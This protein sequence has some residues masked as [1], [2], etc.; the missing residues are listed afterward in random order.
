[1]AQPS[2]PTR[3]LTPP[4]HLLLDIFGLVFRGDRRTDRELLLLRGIAPHWGRNT[5]VS[6]VAAIRRRRARVIAYCAP[7][8]VGVGVRTRVAGRLGVAPVREG[9]GGEWHALGVRGASEYGGA[10]AVV[11]A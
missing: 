9:S 11:R 4:Y 3:A 7:A 5:S 8:G 10:V 2:S 1:M 6:A